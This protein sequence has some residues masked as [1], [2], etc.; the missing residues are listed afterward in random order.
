[1]GQRQARRTG[2]RKTGGRT[3]ER[4]LL[5]SKETAPG[6]EGDRTL[7]R[8]LLFGERNFSP[9]EVISSAS[10]GRTTNRR[11]TRMEPEERTSQGL[12]DGEIRAPTSIS[13]RP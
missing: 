3:L 13:V 5:F 1:M 4:T 12:Y 6:S 10:S 11:E 2:D 8:T 9:E 7:Q